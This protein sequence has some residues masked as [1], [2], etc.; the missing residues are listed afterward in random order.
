LSFAD[1]KELKTYTEKKHLFFTES[2]W[3]EESV[4]FLDEIGVPFF[5][6]ASADLT[7]FPLLEHTAK[8][9]KPIFMSTGMADLETVRKAVELVL[10]FNKNIVL[11]QCTFT[12]P[13]KMET[14]NLNVIKTYKKEFGKDCVIGY[15]GHENGISQSLVAVVIGAK[16]IERHFTLDRTMKGGDHAASLEKEGLRRLIR[17][18]HSAE[19]A[20]GSGE[21]KLL[22]EELPVFQKLSKSLVSASKIPKGTVVTRA[23]LTTKGPGTGISPMRLQEIIGKKTSHDIEEDVVLY[24]KDFE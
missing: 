5:K 10:K 3:D 4:D 18:I 2:G 12:Y 15:S 11:F 21:K 1:F 7:N 6:V 14:L 8:K 23:M 16:V 9:G 17:D 22:P 24:D 13:A 19:L 20:L